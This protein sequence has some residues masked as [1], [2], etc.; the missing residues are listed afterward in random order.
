MA[1]GIRGHPGAPVWGSGAMNFC[2]QCHWLYFF[3][4][5]FPV[6]FV[7]YFCLAPSFQCRRPRMTLDF[8]NF[9][10]SLMKFSI[11]FCP[12]ISFLKTLKELTQFPGPRFID[13][14]VFAL[15]FPLFVLTVRPIFLCLPLSPEKIPPCRQQEPSQ[16]PCSNSAKL[17]KTV[18]CVT[19][20]VENF[21]LI[22]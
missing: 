10:Y 17:S 16:K 1:R 11:S 2:G 14:G 12:F 6:S 3:G 15:F 5:G 19:N 21:G 13:A 7:S 22:I 20:V 8:A 9:Y 18:T 4:F